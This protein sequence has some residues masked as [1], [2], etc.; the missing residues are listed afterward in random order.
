MAHHG[1]PR[2]ARVVDPP[3]LTVELDA[4]QHH[5]SLL[6][7]Q[8]TRASLSSRGGGEEGSDPD[9][10]P[11]TT[12]TTTTITKNKTSRDQHLAAGPL[13]MLCLQHMASFVQAGEAVRARD[14][15]I[16]AGMTTVPGGTTIAF[17]H[18]PALA[19]QHP[20]LHPDLHPHPNLAPPVLLAPGLPGVVVAGAPT[21]VQVQVQ[22]QEG[23]GFAP[24]GS[25]WVGA[26]D[27]GRLLG[28]EREVAVR[29]AAVVTS[30]RVLCRMEV[31]TLRPAM[32]EVAPLLAATL[33]TPY[34]PREVVAVAADL[35]DKHVVACVGEGTG[36]R[37]TG[38]GKTT[39][40]GFAI[41]G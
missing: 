3:L 5:V 23:G 40:K 1:I 36:V 37:R 33:R 13:T 35:I 19:N 11:T 24:P 29:G 15:A 10:S 22:V 39:P 26:G 8:L 38:E 28:A 12:T 17:F 4:A 6:D 2:H 25:R 14:E 9:T 21:P 20:D 32:G 7:K 41:F 34:C 16:S 18:P 30:M 31:E 27:V